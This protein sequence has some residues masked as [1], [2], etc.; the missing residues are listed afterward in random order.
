MI[1]SARGRH[2]GKVTEHLKTSIYIANDLKEVEEAYLD[3][4]HVDLLTTKP[5]EDTDS[6]Y[7]VQKLACKGQVD[8]VNALIANGASR[9]TAA[10]GYAYGGFWEQVNLQLAHGASYTD[11]TY[12]AAAGGHVQQVNELLALEGCHNSATEGYATG[13]HIAQINPYIL[14]EA[15]LN[16]AGELFTLSGCIEGLNQMITKGA[17]RH[18]IANCIE[19]MKKYYDLL[20]NAFPLLA[21]INDEK[22]RELVAESILEDDTDIILKKATNINLLM[23][24]NDLSFLK[25]RALAALDVGTYSLLANEQSI[26]DQL[27]LPEIIFERISSY[28]AGLPEPETRQMMALVKRNLLRGQNEENLKKI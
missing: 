10:C 1:G 25:A 6:D 18:H 2:I 14:T 15:D 28:V 12:W 26:A 13:W 17:N 16:T 3:A 9:T 8:Q 4:G 20:D 27:N 23:T 5:L 7:L 11:V 19:V 24:R 22:L 21:C